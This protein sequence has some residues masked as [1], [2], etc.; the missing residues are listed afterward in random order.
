MSSCM[1]GERPGIIRGVL[2]GIFAFA[3][4]GPTDV[5]GSATTVIV[6]SPGVESFAG[7]T[8]THDTVLYIIASNAIRV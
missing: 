2:A 7:G 6:S 5:R 8:S 3:P 1:S 4:V